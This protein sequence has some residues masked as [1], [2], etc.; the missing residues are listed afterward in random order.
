MYGSFVFA[1][2]RA[3]TKSPPAATQPV[4]ADAGAK[5]STEEG[6]KRMIRRQRIARI[7]SR[8]AI[9]MNLPTAI[10]VESILATI[11]GPN[12]TERLETIN[13]GLPNSR[14]GFSLG[15]HSDWGTFRPR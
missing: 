1:Q 6:G 4:K 15:S 13:N 3:P 11:S 10:S 9:Q 14:R 7:Q 5:P 2:N 8:Q 12:D